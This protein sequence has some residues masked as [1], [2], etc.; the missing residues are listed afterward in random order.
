MLTLYTSIGRLTKQKLQNGT[1]LP[2][3]LMGGQEHALAPHEFMLWSSLAFQILTQE[4]AQSLYQKQISE[5]SLAE[6]PDFSYI[7]RRLLVRGLVIQGGGVTGVDALYR[8]FGHLHIVPIKV[9]SFARFFACLR[10]WVYG[11][12]PL[13]MLLRSLKKPAC[14]PLESLILRISEELSFSISE[15]LGYMEHS[16]EMPS[17]AA[18]DSITDDLKLDELAEQA[19]V[20]H[21]QLP[22]LQGI[23][24][25]YLKK[26]ILLEQ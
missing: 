19:A 15:L 1:E 22:V 2:V 25:L 16:S 21:F 5:Y 3:I 17:Q 13:S 10:A 24:N 8:L 23:A 7:L 4:E 14:T 11:Y 20:H 18:L 12:M 6:T 9:S 26:Q